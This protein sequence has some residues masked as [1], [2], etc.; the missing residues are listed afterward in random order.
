[1]YDQ[2]IYHDGLYIQNPII[3]RWI[4]T[5]AEIVVCITDALF[6]KQIPL[7]IKGIPQDFP[8]FVVPARQVEDKQAFD[9]LHKAIQEHLD[10]SPT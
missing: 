8:G 3:P 4:S 2:D 6:K 5:I 10:S 1:M 9:A 7:I